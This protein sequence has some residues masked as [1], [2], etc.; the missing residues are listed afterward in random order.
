MEMVE[1]QDPHLMF[2]SLLSTIPEGFPLSQTSKDLFA[3]GFSLATFRKSLGLWTDGI[4][5][6]GFVHLFVVDSPESPLV[7]G[8]MQ[9]VGKI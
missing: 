7:V 8:T 4:S 5:R 6:A 3:D 1:A 9:I 2:C